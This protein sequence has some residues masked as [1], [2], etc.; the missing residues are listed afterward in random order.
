MK[1]IH[2]TNSLEAVSGILKY[3]FAY[4]GN[5]RRLCEELLSI[6]DF[7]SR[8]PQQFGMVSFRGYDGRVSLEHIKKFGCYGICVTEEWATRHSAQKVLYVDK[9]GPIF[10]SMRDVFMDAYYELK[11]KVDVYPEDAAR[12]MAYHNKAMA[13]LV[14]VS[15]YAALLTLYEYLEPIENQYQNEWRVCNPNPNY[16][17]SEDISDAIREVSPPKGWANILNV[18]PIANRDLN[19]L[20]CRKGEGEKLRESIPS[21]FE[22]VDIIEIEIEQN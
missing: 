2:H 21:D 19:H 4:V 18:V 20:M 12:E 7:R 13:G 6:H 8:E 16:S 5:R 9:T 10:E 14:G 17:I 15:S 3:G 11:R 22:E 1:L